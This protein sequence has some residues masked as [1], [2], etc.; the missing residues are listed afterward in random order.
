MRREFEAKFTAR[1]AAWP[2]LAPLATIKGREPAARAGPARV[3]RSGARLRLGGVVPPGP[4]A[5]YP[6]RRYSR[7]YVPAW[8][9]MTRNSLVRWPRS[10]RCPTKRRRVRVA[11][12]TAFGLGRGGVHT[13]RGAGRAPRGGVNWMLGAAFV[14]A[15]VR[16]LPALPFGGSQETAATD[17]NSPGRASWSSS[18]S[19]A[20]CCVVDPA[21]LLPGSGWS[22]E[23]RVR[24]LLVGHVLGT[25]DQFDGQTPQGDGVTHHLPRAGNRTGNS[26][27]TA[28]TS[29]GRRW[30]IQHGRV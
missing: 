16:S 24:V 14:N 19:R 18:T 22:V 8:R 5:Y 7:T 20:C 1:M 26:T 12:D 30:V 2:A 23:P 9:R 28:V 3:L 10:S 4:G 21:R 27:P 25:V 17:G 6:L 13:G 29:R 15:S 11:N